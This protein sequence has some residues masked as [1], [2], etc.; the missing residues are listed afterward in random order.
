M[1]SLLMRPVPSGNMRLQEM[2]KRKTVKPSALTS[3]QII[4]IAVVKIAGRLGFAI[5]FYFTT[6]FAEGIPD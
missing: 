5:V 4:F 6:A 3:S 2:E 1:P